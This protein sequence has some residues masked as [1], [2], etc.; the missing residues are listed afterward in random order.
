EIRTLEGTSDEFPRLG[1]HTL[2]IIKWA[3]DYYHC[4]IGEVLRGFLPP[5]P[6]PRKREAWSL[7]PGAKER[8][9][10]GDLPRGK[11]QRALL[12]RF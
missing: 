5:D 9:A 2:E 3:A 1:T 11:V 10:L 12:L 7:A 6:E 8:I 4:P